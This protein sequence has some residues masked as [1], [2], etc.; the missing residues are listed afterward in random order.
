MNTLRALCLRLYGS[1]VLW[2]WAMNGFR[3]VSALVLLPLLLN[4]LPSEELGI[5]FLFFNLQALLP[6]ID[7]GFSVALGRHVS[8]AMGGARELQPL[9]LAP[10]QAETAPNYDLLWRL[11]DTTRHLFRYMALA[12]LLLMGGIGT[13][14]VGLRV[15]ETAQ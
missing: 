1:A 11:L 12:A 6:I 15:H 8:Y 14:A 3:L 7:F 10:V 5:Y 13:W 2:S 9:G 4:R